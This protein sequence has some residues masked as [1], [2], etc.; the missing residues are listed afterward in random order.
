[1]LFWNRAVSFNNL[2]LFFLPN[3]YAFAAFATPEQC[4]A[5][6]DKCQGASVQGHR[7]VVLYA[8]K[9]SAEQHKKDQKLSQKNKE[10]ASKNRTFVCVGGARRSHC[11][12]LPCLETPENIDR[13]D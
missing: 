1:M 7:L 2:F 4:K 5:A 12:P 10:P 9:R 3:R 6:H 13:R 8:K 11:H